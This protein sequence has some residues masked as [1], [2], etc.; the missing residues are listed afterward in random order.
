MQ[1]A[2]FVD[3]TT[4]PSVSDS[5]SVCAQLQTETM[6]DFNTPLRGNGKR[7]E[8]EEMEDTEGD[9]PPLSPVPK[10]KQELWMKAWAKRRINSSNG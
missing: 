5:S 3:V 2:K 9:L 1:T 6:W 7:E 10:N 8:M 4:E